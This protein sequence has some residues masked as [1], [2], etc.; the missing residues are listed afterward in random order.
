MANKKGMRGIL[1]FLVGGLMIS[2]VL[3]PSLALAQNNPPENEVWKIERVEWTGLNLFGWRILGHWRAV[4]RGQRILGIYTGSSATPYFRLNEN[5]KTVFRGLGRESAFM[6]WLFPTHH[7]REK[8][9]DIIVANDKAYSLLEKFD[10]QLGKGETL[11]MIGNFLSHA[12]QPVVAY[13]TASMLVGA[14]QKNEAQ[15]DQGYTLVNVGVVM[16]F[17]G[18]TG[19]MIGTYLEQKSFAYL[20]DAVEY[21]NTAQAK[22]S[23]S[24]RVSFLIAKAGDDKIVPAIGFNF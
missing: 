2:M 1:V 15:F 5:D 24:L 17:L 21:F 20:D 23:L 22:E 18:A 19:Q 3:M 12:S 16:L 14:L 6:Q 11:Y 7:S 9:R 4:K 13:G 10:S 8:L